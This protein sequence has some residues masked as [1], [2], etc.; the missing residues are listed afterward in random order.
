M[1]RNSSCYNWMS[2]RLLLL[3]L[4]LFLL[5]LLLTPNKAVTKRECEFMTDYKK[6][7]F[8]S[9]PFRKINTSL[10]VVHT[11]SV[12]V[13]SSPRPI[14]IIR[15]QNENMK[16]KPVVCT[17]GEWCYYFV[18]VSLCVCFFFLPFLVS[19][20][21]CPYLSK[22][23]RYTER[24]NESVR[25][26]VNWNYFKTSSNVWSGRDECKRHAERTL[27]NRYQCDFL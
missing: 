22:Y 8:P 21:S 23:M 9:F 19:A 4:R 13:N 3:L 7:I 11:M 1:Q 16:H 25:E 20:C 27:K 14:Y 2:S 12:Q 10:C 15:H 18:C 24:F 6:D 5:L 26:K 17:S